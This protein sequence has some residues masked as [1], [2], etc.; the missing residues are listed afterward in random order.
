[1]TLTLTTQA[2][3]SLPADQHDAVTDWLRTFAVDHLGYPECVTHVEVH[4]DGLVRIRVKEWD[5]SA[6][7]G[8]RLD[9]AGR[10][11]TITRANGSW[12]DGIERP[13]L[14]YVPDGACLESTFESVL[15]ELLPPLV[16]EAFGVV[17][18]DV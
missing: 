17:S 7:G 13:E 5:R 8:I 1:M 4:D 3:R 6:G 11:F 9:A 10:P 14:G 18:A 16:A 15:D 2:F 12:S